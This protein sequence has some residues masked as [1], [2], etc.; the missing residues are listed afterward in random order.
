MDIISVSNTL[1]ELQLSKNKS[2]IVVQTTIK[3][4]NIGYVGHLINNNNQNIDV[5]RLFLRTSLNVQDNNNKIIKIG[6]FSKL[7]ASG[8]WSIFQDHKEKHL[9][10]GSEIVDGV[11]NFEFQIKKENTTQITGERFNDHASLN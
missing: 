4:E 8:N 5:D 3:N 1:Q 10:S 11:D 9:T 2:Y 6:N 7:N